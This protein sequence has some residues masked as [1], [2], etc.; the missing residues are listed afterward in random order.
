MFVKK[1]GWFPLN[2]L[3][4]TSYQVRNKPLPTK[5]ICHTLGGRPDLT[6]VFRPHQHAEAAFFTPANQNK[7]VCRAWSGSCALSVADANW[8]ERRWKW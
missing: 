4:V 3:S 7:I 5:D 8:A 2:V 6:M 1:F